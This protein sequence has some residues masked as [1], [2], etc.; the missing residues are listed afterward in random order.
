MPTIFDKGL[1]KRKKQ[2][3]GRMRLRANPL[4]IYSMSMNL[5]QNLENLELIK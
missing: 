1:T 4:R 2:A 5:V 3:K